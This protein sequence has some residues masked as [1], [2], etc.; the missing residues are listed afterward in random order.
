MMRQLTS[1]LLRAHYLLRVHAPLGMFYDTLLAMPFDV[2]ISYPIKRRNLPTRGAQN[3]R[4]KASGWM[5]PRD[6]PPSA[7][8]AASIFDAID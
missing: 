5:A 2:F 7:N 6:I 3:L 4:L 8:W 1:V